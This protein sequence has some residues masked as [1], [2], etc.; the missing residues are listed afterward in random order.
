MRVRPSG[1]L[2]DDAA[3]QAWTR[4]TADMSNDGTWP[5]GG[6]FAT[7]CSCKRL[8]PSGAP[9]DFSVA[10]VYDHM[11][12]R[13]WWGTSGVLAGYF[14]LVK[15]LSAL[16]GQVHGVQA[17]QRSGVQCAVQCCLGWAEPPHPPTGVPNGHCP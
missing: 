8:N 6:V 10:Q 14:S 2:A 13:Y 5:D 11:M 17:C 15:V 3:G 1:A 9:E 7:S 4:W 12:F 16:L